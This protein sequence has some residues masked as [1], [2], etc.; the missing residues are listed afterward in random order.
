MVEISPRNG[1]SD[2][3]RLL[4]LALVL[5]ATPAFAQ[6]VVLSAQLITDELN[7]PIFAT[8]PAGDPR[9]FVVQQFGQIVIIE[10]GTL[11]SQPF[12]SLSG[13][14][15]G[16]GER[17]LLGLAFHPDYAGNGRFFINY[18]DRQ[19]DTRIDACLV[20][21]DPAVA[22]P[23]SCVTILSV[24]QPYPNHN[25]GWIGFGPD[26]YL[27]IGMGDGGS[28]GDPENRAQNPDELL[29]KMLRLDVDSRGPYA[30]PPGNPFANGGGAP[31]IFALGVRNPWR[32]AFDGNELY[33]ADVGQNR[34]EEVTVISTAD[35]GANLGW[36]RMEG[37]DCFQP[38]CDTAGLVLPQHEYSHEDGC[39]I[40]G[41]Y[42]YRGSA[43]P[44]IVGHYFFGDYCSQKVWSFRYVDGQV[45]DLTDWTEQLG[46]TLHHDAQRAAVQGGEGVGA[47]RASPDTAPSMTSCP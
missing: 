3:M 7:S 8:A 11:Q 45:T 23:A 30:I 34:V 6:P 33:I 29:G 27:Y 28:G 39:S 24:A 12:L 31:E 37:K 44:E 22:D 41:G 4:A 38:G 43:I 47:S 35:A 13:K 21:S 16:G 2:V 46:G 32:N 10:D 26:G 9:L 42:V 17:G 14:T 25:G 1:W 15:R 20:S 19:G 40:T 5:F 36:N 18:T